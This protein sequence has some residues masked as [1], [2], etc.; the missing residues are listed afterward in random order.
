MRQFP[1]PNDREC[2]VALTFDVD[3]ETY[4]FAIDPRNAYRRMTML[5]EGMYGTDVGMHHILQL[6]DR[7]ELKGTFFIPGF[8]AELHTELVR[9]IVARGHELGHHGYLHEKPDEMPDEVE[10]HVIVKG[11]EAFEATVGHRPLGYRSPFWA[12]KPQTPALLRKNGFLYDSSLMNDELPFVLG[13]PDGA[14]VELP[15]HWGLDDWPH[16]GFPGGRLST[17]ES[18]LESWSWEFDGLHERRGCF[19]LTMHPEVIGRSTRLRVLEKLIRF[20]R[21]YPRVWFAT[22]GEIAAHCVETAACQEK[23]FPAAGLFP[24]DHVPSDHLD[25]ATDGFIM[26]D[27]LAETERRIAESRHPRGG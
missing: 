17:P 9:E 23:T 20:I 26:R 7:Y 6:L 25:A 4:P 1:W 16:F 18:V 12:I 27:A 15:V 24:R 2:A 8:T 21:G 14:L 11:I 13:T 3:G 19:V 10:Q 22:L 5:S